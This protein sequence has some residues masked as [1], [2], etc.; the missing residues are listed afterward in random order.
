MKLAALLLLAVTIR[1][2]AD[3]P[4]LQNPVSATFKYVSGATVT[5]AQGPNAL[6]ELTIS[7]GKMTA[8]IPAEEMKDIFAPWLSNVQFTES[9]DFET[10]KPRMDVTLKYDSRPYTWGSE[11]SKVTFTFIGG[12]YYM[13]STEIP[14]G[15]DLSE[16]REKKKGKAEQTVGKSGVLEGVLEA[17]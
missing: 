5:L 14:T 3:T 12:E 7:S 1:I 13:R 11:F 4:I 6:E 10:G 16:N 2:S 9:E 8:K 17:K 15:K